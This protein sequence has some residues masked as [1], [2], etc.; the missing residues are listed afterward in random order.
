[1]EKEKDNVLRTPGEEDIH[2]SMSIE[3]DYK[4]LG[5]KKF[6]KEYGFLGFLWL[7]FD[8]TTGRVAWATILLRVTALIVCVLALLLPR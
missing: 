3:E 4:R 8:E 5:L 2:F 6:L 7:M 1:M